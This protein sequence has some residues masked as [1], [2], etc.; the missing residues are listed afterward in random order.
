MAKSN[1][2]DM[3]ITKKTIKNNDINEGIGYELK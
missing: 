2:Q 1:S 3:R